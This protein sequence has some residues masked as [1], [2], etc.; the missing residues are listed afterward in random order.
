MGGR[1]GAR[2][3]LLQAIVATLHSLTLD[4]WDNVT[5]EPQSNNDKV[6]IQWSTADGKIIVCQVKSSEGNFTKPTI[7]SILKDLV[8]DIPDASEHKLILIGT[9]SDGTKQFFNKFKN[10]SQSDLPEKFSSL[11]NFRDSIKL[12]L[13]ALDIDGLNSSVQDK[14]HE[15]L[16]NRG[17][18]TPHINT[19]LISQGLEAQ[20]ARFAT[21]GKKVSRK[22][23]EDNILKWVEFN[24]PDQLKLS[25]TDLSLS[26]YAP[27]TSEFSDSLTE[28]ITLQDIDLTLFFQS[29]LKTLTQ[30]RIDIINLKQNKVP[31]LPDQSH[32]QRIALFGA[33]S[34]PEYRYVSFSDVEIKKISKDAKRFLN[35]K[36][37]DDFFNLGSL[38]QTMHL[39]FSP[40]LWGGTEYIGTEDQKKKK[41]LL[42][43][44]QEQLNIIKDF[45]NTWRKLQDYSIVPL[46]LVNSSNILHSNVEVQLNIPSFVKVLNPND[47]PY[48]K[49]AQNLA[50]WGD[51]E[52]LAEL[53]LR[54]NKDSKVKAYDTNIFRPIEMPSLA[55]I[56]RGLEEKAQKQAVL[57][58]V[59]EG[60]FDYEY[61]NDIVNTQTLECSFKNIKSKDRISLPSYLFVKT[62][63]P[64][65][66]AYSIRSDQTAENIGS[67]AVFMKD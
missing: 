31:Q 47:F 44:F 13:K 22:T 53:L 6:D 24:Y 46:I 36:L 2:G 16:S 48:P 3:Y 66:I 19:K 18:Y 14:M 39:K 32:K 21:N 20:F 51:N 65:E 42:D 35:M 41:E 50:V 9:Y 38:K 28:S 40:L 23:F 37:P 33:A 17:F 52:G 45:E 54:H 59:L 11:F 12:E 58:S 60:I 25:K 61:F 30:W 29:E 27:S 15:F 49:V 34:A 67:I 5:L 1:E 57:S 7:L 26:I 64:F 56:G 8:E 10:I 55:L 63:Q 62:E 43:D 4:N